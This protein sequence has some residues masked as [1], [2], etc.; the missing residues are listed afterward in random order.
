MTAEEANELLT[1]YEYIYVGSQQDLRIHF[2]SIKSKI[3]EQKDLIAEQ[4]KQILLFS[5]DY[6]ELLEE[7]VEDLEFLHP[8]G[9]LFRK[10]NKKL[11]S[12]KK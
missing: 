7:I 3:D 8:E 11:W 1:I 2:W 9:I 4:K 5:K 10:Y 12:Q 6:L